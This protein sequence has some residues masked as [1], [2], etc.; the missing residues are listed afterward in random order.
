MKIISYNINGIRAAVKKGLYD[1]LDQEKPDIFCMQETK[2]QVD[3]IDYK[4]LES[5][6]Y[7]CYWKS[8]LKKGYSGVG[9]ITKEKPLNVSLESGMSLYDD[10]GRI[11]RAD[12]SSFSVLNVYMPSGSAKQERQDF[13]M[14]FLDDFFAYINKLKQDI[15]NLIICGDF[16]ICHTEVDI[17]NPKQNQKTSGFLPEERAWVTKFLENGF[18]DSFRIIHPEMVDKYSWWSYRARAR[19]RNKGWR[20]D[21]LMVSKSIESMVSDADI[22]DDVNHSDHCPV[23]LEIKAKN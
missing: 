4:H 16:N 14:T 18:S 9:I 15:P 19:E 1:W 13:K 22:L 2:A 10:E 23:L 5:L 3:Q 8:A 17:H 6:G 21:Y 11:I 20:I 7:H 12:Y